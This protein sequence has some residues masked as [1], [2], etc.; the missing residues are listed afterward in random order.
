M[1]PPL[2]Q[3]MFAAHSFT[4][5]LAVR[6]RQTLVAKI[7]GASWSGA[8]ATFEATAPAPTPT[9][10][11]TPT[12]S[13]TPTPTPTP[14]ASSRPSPASSPVGGSGY[15]GFGSTPN[16]INPNPSNP[17]PTSTPSPSLPQP[18]QSLNDGV[19][20]FVVLVAISVAV[21]MLFGRKR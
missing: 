21:A 13:P 5:L 19:L 4:K 14:V 7:S 9:P 1:E 3:V 15:E 11:P 20:L 6:K 2:I 10:T 12:A 16:P 17:I 18:R 8:I